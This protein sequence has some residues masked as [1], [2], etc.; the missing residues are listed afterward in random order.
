[1]NLEPK[2]DIAFPHF[3]WKIKQHNK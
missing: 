1:M 3:V 2:K